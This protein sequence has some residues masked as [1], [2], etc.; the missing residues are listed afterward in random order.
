M[1]KTK[2]R[3]IRNKK[4][5]IRKI[6]ISGIIVLVFFGFGVFYYYSDS[7]QVEIM[8]GLTIENMEKIE[9]EKKIL[10]MVKGYPIEQMVPYIIEK[11]PKVAAFL[12]SIAKKESNWGVR[13]PKYQGRDC[14]NYWGYKGPN[15]VGSGGHS[16][17]NSRKEAVDIVGKRI[18]NLVYGQ[19]LDTPSEMIV[20]KCGSSCKGHSSFG[21]RK[22]I[23]DVN[24]YY[25]QLQTR[26]HPQ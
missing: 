22:W 26:L 15:R 6:V 2:L 12:I 9:L 23:S 20:W 25:K 11:D 17:F 7:D 19:D 14:F 5:L 3:K 8:E 16:C 18:E 1:N 21:V 10:E 13:H 4:S 24:Y